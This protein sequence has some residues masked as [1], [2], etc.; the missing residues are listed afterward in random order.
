MSTTRVEKDTLGE[1]QIP[2]DAYWGAQT[3]RAVRNFPVSGIRFPPDFIRALGMIKGACAAVNLVLGL[4]DE[5]IAGA[6]IRA[7]EEVAQGKFDGQFPVDIFQSGSGTSTNM[8][9]NEVIATRANE[10]LTGSR[11]TGSPV[12]PNDHVNMAQSSNDVIPAAIHLS[13]Y[14]AAH[15]TL[16]PALNELRRAI[17]EKRR[18]YGSLVKTGRTHLMDAMPLTVAQELSGW[19]SQVE[20]AG[21]RIGSALPRLAELAIGG[22]AVGTGVNAPPGFGA[23]VAQI[24]AAGTKIEFREARNHFEAQASRDAVVEL[25]GHLK[26][27]ATA[28]IKIANDLRWM[29]SGPASGLAEIMIPPLQPGSSMMP[30]KVNPVIPEAARMAAAQVIGNDV[31]ISLANSM[32][33]FQLNVMLPVIAYNILQSVSL[34]AGVSRLLAEKVIGGMAA[35]EEHI[36]GVLDRNLMVGTVLAPVTGYEKAAGVIEKAMKEGT[37]VK[38]AVVELGYLSRDEAERLLDPRSM[39]GSGEPPGR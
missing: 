14:L 37:T 9:A 4:L 32:G 28:L 2:A 8:N 11:R 22:T 1:V 33:E 19:E 39:T 21:E 26:T 12:H 27:F 10:M 29:N 13:A 35:D 34:L 38:Q 23:R 16:L 25:S 3:E 24:L 5:R 36:R 20:Y 15:G 7:S 18:H 6:V 31:V 30:G 17:G